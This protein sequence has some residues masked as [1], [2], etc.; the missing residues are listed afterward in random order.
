LNIEPTKHRP[1]LNWLIALSVSLALLSPSGA[2]ADLAAAEKLVKS[3]SLATQPNAVLLEYL[4]NEGHDKL[5]PELHER[6]VA[7]IVSALRAKTLVDPLEGMGT[8]MSTYMNPMK[9]VKQSLKQQFSPENLLR[10]Q[11]GVGASSNNQQQQQMQ[12]EMESVMVDPWVRGLEAATALHQAGY[13]D[14]AR[15]FYK[16]CLTSIGSMT[17][18][19]SRNDWVQ[20]RCIAGA[21]GLGP[22]E[23]GSLFA[24]L[25]DNPY[26]DFGINFAALGGKQPEMPVQPEIQAVAAKGLGQLVGSGQLTIEQR[27]G[28][29]Q[30]IIGMAN[31][32]KQNMVALTGA[33][34]GLS[35]ADDSR[36][37]DP[38]NRL[39]KKGRPDE[40]QSVA[41]G[42]LVVGYRVPNAVTAMRKELKVG[43]GIGAKYK[44]AKSFAPFS[45]GDPS[46]PVGSEQE[47]NVKAQTRYLAARALIRAED[48][49][50][51]VWAGKY[52]DKRNVP[53]GDFD[54]RPDM[55]QDL[56]ERGGKRSQTVLAEQ[57][58][59][60][61]QNKWLEAWMRIGLFELGDRSQL[62]ELSKL[63]DKTDWDFGRGS[64]AR[65]YKRLKPILWQGAKLGAMAYAGGPTDTDQLRRV[66]LNFAFAE[67]DRHSAR[68]R[69]RQLK[70]SQFRWQFSDAMADIDDPE[71]L[72]VLDSFLEDD[73]T[74]VRLSAAYALV[75]QS[76]PATVDLLVEALS[77]D[78]GGEDGESR[79]PEV[80]AALL[81]KLLH[82]FPNHPKTAEV[83]SDPRRFES[84]SVRLMALA[85]AG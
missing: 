71:C 40:I 58:T 17:P 78:Y 49:A 9:M 42:G 6:A 55:V 21:M 18:I 32:K 82:T 24:E 22:A 30:A 59:D 14:D 15:N 73:D 51:Y 7:Q 41:L 48:E 35:F 47:G 52:L 3:G 72:P 10:S 70:T 34:Q 74:S 62:G 60:G 28:V 85:A 54:Y 31:V 43:T 16:G 27:D 38:L 1:Q 20:D 84:P 76:S 39:W 5:P 44:K 65:W 37:I 77:L 36:A 2:S 64:A 25:Y 53:D 68:G 79:N 80:R 23:A 57:V 12:Q 4:L 75:G 8:L 56:V 81:R 45:K 46:Q 66:I 61:H 11:L 67:R 63:T 83:L 13:T 29:M 69:E 33:V 50:G 26:L 19:G